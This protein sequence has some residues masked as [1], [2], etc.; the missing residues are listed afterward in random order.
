[1]F[2][3]VHR[4]TAAQKSDFSK[5]ALP[6]A[7]KKG[8]HC[9]R[10]SPTKHYCD[11]PTTGSEIWLLQVC[12]TIRPPKRTQCFK[13]LPTQDFR[14][15]LTGSFHQNVFWAICSQWLRDPVAPKVLD[16]LPAKKGSMF[17][18]FPDQATL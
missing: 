9:L 4:L 5:C 14:N 15:A 17:Q 11:A 7:P 6:S 13:I 16:Y 12:L 8:A 10:F 1:M 2:F 18:T 3:L